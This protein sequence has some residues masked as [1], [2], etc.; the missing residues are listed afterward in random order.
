MKLPALAL[1]SVVALATA[2]CAHSLEQ[3]VEARHEARLQATLDKQPLRHGAGDG[4]GSRNARPAMAPPADK[5]D[6]EKTRL[7][8]AVPPAET[9][10][11]GAAKGR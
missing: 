3:I 6:A 8:L 1:L 11:S 10:E 5:S 9:P 4:I 7:T 2:S